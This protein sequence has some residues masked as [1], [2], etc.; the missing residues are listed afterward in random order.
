MMKRLIVLILL[1]LLIGACSDEFLAHD[2]VYKTNDHMFFS[3]WGYQ[4]VTAEDAQKSQ[5]QGWWGKEIPYIP[6]E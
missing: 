5:E 4:D 1:A 2:T 6:A 3:W